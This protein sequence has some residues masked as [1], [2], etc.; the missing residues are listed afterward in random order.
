MPVVL[1]PKALAVGVGGDI[2]AR[3]DAHRQGQRRAWHTERP[4]QG[5]PG[6]PL[7]LDADPATW[8]PAH[9]RLGDTAAMSR[10]ARIRILETLIGDKDLDSDMAN[11]AVLNLPRV[12]AQRAKWERTAHGAGRDALVDRLEEATTPDELA[13]EALPG[14]GAPA[15]LVSE[16]ARGGEAAPPDL[17]LAALEKASDDARRQYPEASKRSLPFAP[18]QMTARI[19][20]EGPLTARRRARAENEANGGGVADSVSYLVDLAGLVGAP[21]GGAS[22]PTR[23]TR[24]SEALEVRAYQLRLDDALRATVLLAEGASQLETA[25]HE[26]NGRHPYEAHR[27]NAAAGRAAEALRASGERIASTISARLRQSDARFVAD[28]LTAMAVTRTG[29]QEYLDAMLAQLLVILRTEPRSMTP[30]AAARILGALGGMLERGGAGGCALDAH[31]GI[32]EDRREANQRFL[33]LFDARCAEVV[34]LFL[35]EELGTLH[36]AAAAAYLSEGVVRKLLYRAAQLRFG[37]LPEHGPEAL[38]LM[39]RIDA[40]VRAQYP[41]LGPALPDLARRYCQELKSSAV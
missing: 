24:L 30:P 28:A 5:A 34:P 22:E 8:A 10:R 3:V 13:G 41:L 19:A 12:T 40:A 18:R 33:L 11:D 26:L 23:L 1:S 37:L 38:G 17:A 27:A 14:E 2:L 39:R 15:P 6:E 9:Y 35:E 32:S 4:A 16:A 31:A 20:G 7:A 36:E 29:H 21:G 25:W